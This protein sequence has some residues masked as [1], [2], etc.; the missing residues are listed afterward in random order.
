MMT[1]YATETLLILVL[2]IPTLATLSVP[3]FGKLPNLREGTVILAGIALVFVVMELG[4]REQEETSLHLLTL[5]PGL[6]LEFSAEPLGLIFAGIA[7]FLWPVTTLYAA[8][9][10]RGNKEKHQTR[11]FFCFALAIVAAMGIAFANNLLTLFV[12]YE[13]MTLCTYPLVTHAGTD[14]ARQSGRTY[15]GILMLSSIGFQLPMILWIWQEAG[16]LD[17]LPGGLLEGNVSTEVTT[18]LFFLA[19]FGVGK[20]ALM[21]LHRW[22]PA[23]MVAPTPVSALLHAVAV[24]KAGVFTIVKFI[25]YVFGVE[26]LRDIG[27]FGFLHG[28][29]L[30]CLAGATVIIA[31]LIALR[32]DNLKR[33]LAYSTISQLSYVTMS[34]A[35]L[36]YYSVL[37]ACLHIVAHAFGKIT[38]FFAA[39][40]IYTASKKANV[41]QLDG[42][43]R[44]MPL[45]MS[46]FAIGAL[47]MIGVPP[48]VG[49]VSKWYMLSGAFDAAAWGV[50][51]V[52]ILSTLLNAGYFLPIIARAFF[53]HPPEGSKIHGEAP[54]AMRIAI[55]I[56]GLGTLAL[57]FASG[58]LI[59]FAEHIPILM[60]E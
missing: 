35:V 14:K 23:A 47:S 60:R 54:L 34:A 37:A 29:W 26:Y 19:I 45:T 49:F 28:G 9:Y 25:V 12:F 22:L 17:F 11:F 33:R 41:S 21:P 46:A 2:L 58:W 15:L 55:G 24:V 48:T 51:G 30:V 40:S 57:F 43:G 53:R 4:S 56:T 7:S 20:A 31:S 39:G 3:V 10:M 50:I 6:S 38:L 16:T 44:L 42:V 32:Q 18:A 59:E 13:M 36:S 27:Q 52:I 1:A 8:G 5:F